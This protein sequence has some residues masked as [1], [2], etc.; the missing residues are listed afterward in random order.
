MKKNNW[1]ING[2]A[3]MK[4]QLVLLTWRGGQSSLPPV[5]ESGIWT[6]PSGYKRERR[7]YGGY[8]QVLI[9]FIYQS[10]S[11]WCANSWP[12]QP[13][14]SCGSQVGILL[15]G[16]DPYSPLMGQPGGIWSHGGGKYYT[17]ANKSPSLRGKRPCLVITCKIGWYANNMVV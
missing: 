10:V 1:I 17:T 12:C 6:T 15:P 9:S 2:P 4:H 5:S 14:S 8:W 11:Q 3:K 16:W 13:C 7:G